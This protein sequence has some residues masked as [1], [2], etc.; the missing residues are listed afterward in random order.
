MGAV[1]RNTSEEFFPGAEIQQGGPKILSVPKS[2]HWHADFLSFL[3][4]FIC[5]MKARLTT[6]HI[7]HAHSRPLKLVIA[8]LRGAIRSRGKRTNCFV[9]L[10]ISTAVII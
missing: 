7:K 2:L 5:A 9:L 10:N 6:T 4:M 1:G 3:I 8:I